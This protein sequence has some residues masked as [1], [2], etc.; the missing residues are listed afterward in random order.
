MIEQTIAE[1]EARLRSVHGLGEAERAEV[2]SLLR[3]LRAEAAVALAANGG[4]LKPLVGEGAH[5]SLLDKLADS[6]TGFEATH[7][8]LTGIVNRISTILA[9]MGI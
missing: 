5:E 9:N 6:V 8:K 2:E 4:T 3:Q 7:P 1:L